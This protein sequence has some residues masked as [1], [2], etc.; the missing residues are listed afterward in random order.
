M[1]LSDFLPSS[2]MLLGKCDKLDR[3]LVSTPILKWP[4]IMK[5]LLKCIQYSEIITQMKLISSNPIF[6][7]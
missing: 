4:L 7:L 1:N 6:Q 3:T 5:L 2:N